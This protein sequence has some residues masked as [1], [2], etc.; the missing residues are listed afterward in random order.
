[1]ESTT[2]SERSLLARLASHSS[3]AKTEDRSARTEAARQAFRD[4]FE[5]QVDPEG[6]LDPDE[7]ARRA[8]NARKAFYTRL[9][10]KS[11]RSRRRAAESRRAAARFEEEAVEAT[12]ALRECPYEDIAA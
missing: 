12:A 1:M 2:L 3:W 7:R 10:L 6:T 5:Q 11:V 9:A 4:R 8:E